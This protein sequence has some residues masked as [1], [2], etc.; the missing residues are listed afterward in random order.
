[1]VRKGKWGRSFFYE[2]SFDLI[3]HFMKIAPTPLF[4][5]PHSALVAKVDVYSTIN[6]G[7]TCKM[8]IVSFC[9]NGSGRVS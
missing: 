2:N 3:F 5:F 6:F 8:A 1:M 9:L 7:G 4:L